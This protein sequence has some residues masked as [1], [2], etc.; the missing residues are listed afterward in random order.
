MRR[1]GVEAIQEIV[2]PVEFLTTLKAE[3]LGDEIYV[4]TPKN[5]VIKLPLGAT[6]V[7]FAYQIHTD[8]GHRCRGA[9][10]DGHWAP[11]NCSLHTGERVEILTVDDAGPRFD[12]LIPELQY[13][14]SPLAKGK[15]RR[16]FRRRSDDEKLRL[17]RQ[18]LYR[19]IERL[20]LEVDDLTDLIKRT[21][22]QSEEEL[23]RDIGGCDLAIERILPELLR[24][25]GESQ[26]SL[27][28]ESGA[29][30]VPV[31]GTG[32][33]GT[34]F[35]LCCHPLPGDDIVG[36]ILPSQR[37]VEVHRSDCT[38]FLDKVIEDRTPFVEVK[39]GQARETHLACMEI[40]S[41]DRPF[42]LRDVWTIISE[43][44]INVS[45]VDVQV[46]KAQDVTTIICI[47]VEDWLQFNR[48]LVRI[49]DLPG[50]IRVRRTTSTSVQHEHRLE[51]A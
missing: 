47:D 7:D 10:V 50:M 6:P 42:L 34:S 8:V 28:S 16:W 36:Y 20:S 48:I 24:L 26:F 40:Y 39:W 3:A 23:F 38:T 2:D 43:E 19:I 5:K 21:A 18:Q 14:R 22:H 33:L 30:S 51:P 13:T 46:H 29:P 31:T 17:G 32:G 11:L 27:A 4:Y 25:Y 37:T 49:E 12:W 15:I 1:F 35:A 44:D 45:D 9:L 41:L